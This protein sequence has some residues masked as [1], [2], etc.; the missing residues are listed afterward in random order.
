LRSDASVIAASVQ[1][2]TTFDTL[3]ERLGVFLIEDV[4]PGIVGASNT[5]AT[6]LNRRQTNR[7]RTVAQLSALNKIGDGIRPEV[8]SGEHSVSRS[9]G[10]AWVPSDFVLEFARR[11]LR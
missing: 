8:H 6:A 11:D 9:H 10:L 5:N 2:T 1:Q 7:A 4:R 3:F